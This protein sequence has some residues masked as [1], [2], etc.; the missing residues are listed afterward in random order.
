ML[1]K[2][3]KIEFPG[4]VTTETQLTRLQVRKGKGRPREAAEVVPSAPL[5][6]SQASCQPMPETA[7]KAEGQLF[8]FS[9]DEVCCVVL[10]QDPM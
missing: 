3:R 6:L 10:G 8:P 5:Q 7:G 4:L 9:G 1:S 2:Q